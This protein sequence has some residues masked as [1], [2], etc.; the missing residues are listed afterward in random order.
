MVWCS[1]RLHYQAAQAA[2]ACLS[3][4]GHPGHPGHPA[5]A[6]QA[7][8]KQC[9]TLRQWM[10]VMH[11][12]ELWRTCL[13]LASMRSN[14]PPAAA[15]FASARPQMV[16]GAVQPQW[17]LCDALQRPEGMRAIAG[18]AAWHQ[19]RTSARAGSRCTGV[20]CTAPAGCRQAACHRTASAF[21]WVPSELLNCG[22]RWRRV[23]L[24]CGGQAQA[25]ADEEQLEGL[26][27]EHPTGHD[28][29]H[30]PHCTVHRLLQI[31]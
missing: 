13:M 10:V 31:G 3:R 17:L 24:L 30:V 15:L 21:T 1:A 20:R 7:A 5:G 8:A 16:H 12:A 6:E 22:S 2:A 25:G 28:P 27:H 4:P 26:C 18:C 19:R 9:C 14:A 11:S 29:V 23:S